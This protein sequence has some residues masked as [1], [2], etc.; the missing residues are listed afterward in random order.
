MNVDPSGL[1]YWAADTAEDLIDC[2]LGELLRSV[3]AEV[4]DRIALVDGV[5][6][7]K[8]RRRWTYREMVGIAEQVARSLLTRFSPGDRVAICAANCAEWVFLQHGMSFAGL[9]MVPINPAYRHSEL[10]TILRKS[11]AAGVFYA[12]E[13]RGNDIRGMMALLLPRLPHLREIVSLSDWDVFLAQEDQS[14]QFP[15]VEN[16]DLLHIQFTSGTTGVPKGACL[17]H[18]GVINTSRF[19]GRRAGF[20]DGGVWINAMP[21]FHIAGPVVTELATITSRGTYVLV[22]GFDPQ[23][24]LELIETEKGNATL[25]VPTMI[26]AL[27]EHPDFA[28]RD[29][30]SMMTILTGAAVVP[31]ALVHRTKRAFNSNLSILFGQTEVNGVVCQTS[32]EDSVEDQSETLGKPL[33]HAEV[34]IADTETGEIKPIGETGEICVRGYQNMLG[35]YGLEEETRET[36]RADGWLRTGDMGIM[37]DRG[38]FRIAGR[39]KDMII[40]GG[41]NIYPREIEDVLFSH[42]QVGQI[43]V[44]GIADERWGEAIAA[45]VLPVDPLDPPSIEDLHAHCRRHLSPHKSP[46]A[47]Y[48]VEEYPLTPSGKIQ[49]FI[50]QD[51]I[52]S[53]RLVQAASISKTSPAT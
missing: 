33:P 36:I 16:S 2:T 53:G 38:Y 37:D 15:S 6:D 5:A 21:M 19:V 47:W 49:K 50:L 51:W 44:V 20:P 42:P 52:A 10:E 22:P 30:S 35:Y 48:F 14:L 17:H 45:V 12:D 8:L 1:S 7:P 3:A 29:L 34:C 27:L 11:E 32:I 41:M 23:L 26:L 4:P 39:L 25:V 40:R 13:Y 24:M 46:V 43:S 9:V 31:A 28:R 18:K